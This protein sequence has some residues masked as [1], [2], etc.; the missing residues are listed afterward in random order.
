MPASKQA[1]PN[2]ALCWS[3]ATPPMG[4]ACAQQ[5]GV[6]VGKVRARG[7]H[8]RHQRGGNVQRL[9][10]VRVPCVAVHVEQ[11]GARGIA[12]V[13]GVH[14]AAGEL[15]QQPAVDRAEG[16]L[17]ALGLR[18]RA[19]HVVE[20]PAQLGAGEVGVDHQAGLLA[21]GVGHALLAQLRAQRLGAAVLPDDGVVH[22]WPVLRFHTTVVSR[23]LVMPIACDVRGL[24]PAFASASRAVASWLPRS[25]AGR[26]RPSRAADRSAEL[27]LR[28]GDDAAFAVEH[29]AARTG[30]ALVEGEQVGGHW[31]CAPGC[32]LAPSPSGGRLG[33]GLR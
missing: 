21:D 29:D 14:L 9:Q 10:Q 1:W 19:G 26:A 5:R 25:P 6:G 7:L 11:H 18:A 31:L 3:P 30:G 17:A 13:G 22:G 20:Q 28:D 16:Q 8:L 12:H 4:S 23:W 27:A 2:R 33:S 24:Q 32:T 15:P